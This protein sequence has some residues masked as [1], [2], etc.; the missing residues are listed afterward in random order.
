MENSVN[1]WKTIVGE[2]EKVAKEKS[3]SI[4]A[5]AELTGMRQSNISRIFS[6]K[7]IP[8][9]ETVCIIADALNVAIGVVDPTFVKN[10]VYTS[11]R[12]QMMSDEIKEQ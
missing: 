1:Q 10:A 4:T 7:Y 12:E 6:L 2:L 5:L 3:I 8:K 9:L 11:I